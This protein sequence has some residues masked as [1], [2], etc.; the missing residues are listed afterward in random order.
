MLELETLSTLTRLQNLRLEDNLIK[1]LALPPAA[2]AGDSSSPV[3]CLPS[4]SLLQLAGNRLIDVA[5]VDK[6]AALPGLTEVTL[7]GNPVAKK[8]VGLLADPVIANGVQ[9]A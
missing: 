6:L 3:V 4:L 7:A 8:Q 9:Q 5:D 2:L 1:N